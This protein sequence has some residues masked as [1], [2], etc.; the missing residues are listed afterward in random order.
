VFKILRLPDLIA[1]SLAAVA[2]LTL[3]LVPTVSTESISCGGGAECTSQSGTTTLVQ[4]DGLVVLALLLVPVVLTGLLLATRDR[5]ARVALVVALGVG[6]LVSA[7][8]I[9][10][11]FLPALAASI[12]AVWPSRVRR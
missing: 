7:M 4:S 10:L 3:A 6:C 9:G 2:A 8:S 11:F 1:V 5:H 12:L